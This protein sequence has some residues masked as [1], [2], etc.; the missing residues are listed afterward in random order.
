MH[1]MTSFVY[2]TSVFNLLILPRNDL[3]VN[4]HIYKRVDTNYVHNK[5]LIV[6]I[7]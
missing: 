3:E 2:K 4:I 5:A 1:D 7:S 6:T